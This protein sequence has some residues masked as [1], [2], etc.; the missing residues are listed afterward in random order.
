[1]RGGRQSGREEEEKR[2]GDKS[3]KMYRSR[4]EMDEEK[5]WRGRKG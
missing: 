2:K 4:K 1:M 3:V 5:K